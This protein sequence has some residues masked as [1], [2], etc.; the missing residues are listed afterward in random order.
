[1]SQ[2]SG[3]P[4]TEV[5]V[6]LVIRRDQVL[7]VFN[8]RW[9]TFTLPM[10]KRRRW[11]DPHATEVREEPWVEAAARAAA[12]CLGR[13]LKEEFRK[14]L[15]C[16]GHWQGDATGEVKQYHHQGFEVHVPPET[17]PVPGLIHEWLAPGDILD[18]GRRPISW[19]ARY[20]IG[21]WRK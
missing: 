15:D 6:A 2:S 12:E 10:T 16:E 1:M 14:V 3:F 7:L 8:P 5:A 4:H 9:G 18:K 11:E 21:E 19:T 17:G 20:L 13:T